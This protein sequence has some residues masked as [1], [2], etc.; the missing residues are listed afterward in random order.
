[1]P[2]YE[3]VNLE[4][5]CGGAADEV[6]QK[7]LSEVLTNINDPNT[8]S[9]RA[10]KISLSFVFKPTNDRSVAEVSFVCEAKIVPVRALTSTIVMSRENGK[11]TAY[12]QQ[13]Q[14]ESLFPAEPTN[15]EAESAQ[16]A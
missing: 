3:L 10:R 9:E 11:V 15:S 16:R 1:M 14:Q 4:T 2:K 8:D 7:T 5:I 13:V 12:T 6:F